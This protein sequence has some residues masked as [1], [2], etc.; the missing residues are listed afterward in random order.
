[1]FNSLKLYSYVNIP[2]IMKVIRK[3][4]RYIPEIE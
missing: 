3:I 1:M 4:A 2:Q